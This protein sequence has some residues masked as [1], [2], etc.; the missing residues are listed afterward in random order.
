[1]GIGTI[2][3]RAY[4]NPNIFLVWEFDEVIEAGLRR[5]IWFK[6]RWILVVI[7]GSSLEADP[8]SL[9]Y[10]TDRRAQNR[11]GLSLCGMKRK[12]IIVHSIKVS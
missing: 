5:N 1:M 9:T 11:G 2:E 3:R 4:L 10:E 6:C 12:R 7:L 8:I